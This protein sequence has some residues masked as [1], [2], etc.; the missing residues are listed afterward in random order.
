ME[1]QALIHKLFIVEDDEDDKLLLSLTLQE[2]GMLELTRFFSSI[3][4]LINSYKASEH[5]SG[6]SLILLDVFIEGEKVK[7]AITKIRNVKD[8]SQ[9]PI[10]VMLGAEIE[11]GY[12][13]EKGLDVDGY[14]A[15]P[16]DIKLLFRYIEAIS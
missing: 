16:L 15:K 7:K 1:K 9:V 12:L 10:V 8:L 3:Q 14:M 5:F 13:K 11:K 2:Y 4:D 6:P